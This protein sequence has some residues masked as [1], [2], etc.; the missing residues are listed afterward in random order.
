MAQLTA[1]ADELLCADIT[2]AEYE[3]TL[4]GLGAPLPIPQGD[5]IVLAEYA[6]ERCRCAFFS[7]GHVPIVDVEPAELGG[8]A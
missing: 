4:L 5:L 6:L 3:H 7:E 2:S 8:A 1:L